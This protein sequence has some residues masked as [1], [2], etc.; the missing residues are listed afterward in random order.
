MSAGL[1]AQLSNID[2]KDDEAGCSKRMKALL[3]Q[4]EVE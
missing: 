4:T 1:I 2:L 3:F